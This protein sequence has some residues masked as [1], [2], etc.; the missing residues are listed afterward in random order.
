DWRRCVRVSSAI[1]VETLTVPCTADNLEEVPRSPSA[2]LRVPVVQRLGHR[3]FTAVTRVRI[4]S[5]TPF[6][7]KISTVAAMSAHL[8][9]SR[10]F[11]FV[12]ALLVVIPA[13]DPLLLSPVFLWLTDV[14]AVGVPQLKV[15][16][17]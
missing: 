12:P 7:P 5:G 4:P 3:P 16:K 17:G 8:R 11:A 1:R 6:L 15:H 14:P 9:T 13:G 2:S 10:G